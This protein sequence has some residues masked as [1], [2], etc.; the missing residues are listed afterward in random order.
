ME[1]QPAEELIVKLK[2]KLG[3][4]VKLY[5]NQKKIKL[6]FNSVKCINK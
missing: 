1:D 3:S 4:L 2:E 5:T 6:F